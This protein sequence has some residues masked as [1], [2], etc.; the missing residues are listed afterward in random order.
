MYPYSKKISAKLLQKN[1]LTGEK[2][3]IFIFSIQEISP[4]E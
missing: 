1:E 2:I 3:I 4:N